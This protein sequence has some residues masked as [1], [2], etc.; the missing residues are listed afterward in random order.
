MDGGD[1][2][3]KALSQVH[4]MTKPK[5]LPL[6]LLIISLATQ[7]DA[8][9]AQRAPQSPFGLQLGMSEEA[10]RERLR[11]V[12]T[13][14][15]EEREEEEGG[16]QE[17]WILKRDTKFNYLIAKFSSEHR[18]I[19]ITVVARPQQVR[20]GDVADLDTASRASDGQN[21]SYKWKVQP[22][23]GARAYVINA[24]GSNAEFLTSYSVYFVQ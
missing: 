21:Y 3:R 15:K 7:A 18:L 14:Q 6:L 10:A 2:A 12:A 17:V 13:Q 4:C 1:S 16:E 8:G 5:A 19:L 9:G 22:G 11:K 23:K 20:Y 24:R